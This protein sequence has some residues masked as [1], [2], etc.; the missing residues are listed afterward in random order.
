MGGAINHIPD[1]KNMV[2]SPVERAVEL[3]VELAAEPL[4]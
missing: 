2:E 4:L 3:P 1:A